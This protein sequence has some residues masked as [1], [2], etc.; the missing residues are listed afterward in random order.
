M[1][2]R[3]WMKQVDELCSRVVGVSASTMEDY[4]WRDSFEDELSPGQAL[5]YFLEE[6]GYVRRYPEIFNK[7]VE[8][9]EVYV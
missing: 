9:S 7:F 3:T 4:R 1:N 8:D 5:Y 6:N 2:F